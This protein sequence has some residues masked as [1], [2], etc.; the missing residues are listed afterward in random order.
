M[1][2]RPLLERQ[3]ARWLDE[4]QLPANKAAME[5]AYGEILQLLDRQQAGSASGTDAGGDGAAGG[6]SEAMDIS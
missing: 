2:V 3:C 1:Q 6:G 5:R 4:C